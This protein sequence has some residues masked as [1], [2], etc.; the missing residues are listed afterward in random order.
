MF[1]PFQNV[2]K[3]VKKEKWYLGITVHSNMLVYMYIKIYM[4]NIQKGNNLTE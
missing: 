4:Y 1:L 3:V 2:S